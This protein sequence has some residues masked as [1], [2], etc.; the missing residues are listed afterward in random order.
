MMMDLVSGGRLGG[1]STL[2]TETTQ[3]PTNFE[4]LVPNALQIFHTET[5]N[6][7]PPHKI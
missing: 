1:N 5:L 2:Q 4:S 6:V 3:L 7:S